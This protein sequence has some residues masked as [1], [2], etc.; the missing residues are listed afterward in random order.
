MLF[1]SYSWDLKATL[2]V[3]AITIVVMA[4]SRYRLSI[5]NKLE[6]L[7][8]L[9]VVRVDTRDKSVGIA[10]A[11]KMQQV[12]LNPEFV[13]QCQEKNDLNMIS[14]G[15]YLSSLRQSGEENL[16][17]WLDTAV[18]NAITRALLKGLGPKLG[19]AVLPAL[20]TGLAQDTIRCVRPVKF[21]WCAEYECV[22]VKYMFVAL[23]NCVMLVI[24]CTSIAA[25]LCPH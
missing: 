17:A 6:Q 12:E 23:T 11:S 24:S 8:V 25:I 9:R 20:G 7:D 1:P 13:K 2:V 21:F 3:G 22:C 5:K 18:Q 14:L 16:P 19:S 10:E 15:D 4:V